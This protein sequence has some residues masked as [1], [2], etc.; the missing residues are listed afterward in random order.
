M[1]GSS[2]S[3]DC[4]YEQVWMHDVS[5]DMNVKKSIDAL[6]IQHHKSIL[7]DRI[8]QIKYILKNVDNANSFDNDSND[9]IIIRTRVLERYKNQFVK[10]LWQGTAHRRSSD[11]PL[12]CAT[13]RWVSNAAAERRS[14]GKARIQQPRKFWTICGM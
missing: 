4:I 12:R 7:I 9:K 1:F 5:T 2:R 3:H 6:T 11:A 13:I 10:C 8:G 14:C